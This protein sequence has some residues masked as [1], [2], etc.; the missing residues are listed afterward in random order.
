MFR[1]APDGALAAASTVLAGLSTLAGITSSS[2]GGL[3]ERIVL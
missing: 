2:R 3:H 1:M